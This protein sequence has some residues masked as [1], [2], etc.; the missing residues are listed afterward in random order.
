MVEIFFSTA[1]FHYTTPLLKNN[2]GLP[3]SYLS[4]IITTFCVAATVELLK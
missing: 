1:F 2:S 3:T 4:K